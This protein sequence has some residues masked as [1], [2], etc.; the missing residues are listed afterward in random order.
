[1]SSVRNLQSQT[2]DLSGVEKVAMSFLKQDRSESVKKIYRALKRDHPTMPA[3][4]K[5]RIAARQGKPGKQHQGPPYKGPLTK[6]ADVSE[7]QGA[8]FGGALG[9]A[10]GMAALPFLMRKRRDM[11]QDA[12]RFSRMQQVLPSLTA[13]LAPTG[14]T[15]KILDAELLGQMAMQAPLMTGAAGAA[16]GSALASGGSEKKASDQLSMGDIA[17]LAGAMAGGGAAQHF[18]P[19]VGKSGMTKFRK[20][21]A[22]SAMIGGGSLTAKQLLRKIKDLRVKKDGFSGKSK[23]ASMRKVAFLQGDPQ[24]M[25]VAQQRMVEIWAQLMTLYVLYW[26]GHW[27]ASGPNQNADHELFTRL[28]GS[29][30]KPIDE[31][32]EKI[33][34]YFGNG[35]FSLPQTMQMVSGNLAQLYAR[36]E[37]HVHLG[38]LAEDYFQ[39]LLKQTYEELKKLGVMPLGLD[40][41]L[42]AT[43]SE[44]ETHSYL[45][46]QRAAGVEQPVKVASATPKGVG[47]IQRYLSNFEKVRK[48][49][50]IPG[51]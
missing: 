50:M 29:T 26:D 28:Y 5:A 12:T 15:Q 40:D 17:G 22:V 16:V 6:Q 34:G 37:D 23:Q 10:A 25:Q 32:A 51:R 33:H 47:P 8:L 24:A 35:G 3:A 42:M 13:V 9:G 39:A 48:I 30:L 31:I 4:M 36:G 38:L 27:K 2:S 1:M 45:L 18:L 21:A 11:I 14:K 49:G 46:Q 41:W 7:S 20:G 44:F 43:A 19:D